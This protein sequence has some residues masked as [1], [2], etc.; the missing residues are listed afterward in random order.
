LR[1]EGLLAVLVQRDPAGV[2]PLL[3]RRI[4]EATAVGV[5]R[6][7]SLAAQALD[8]ALV[9]LNRLRGVGL[10]TRVKIARGQELPKSLPPL[11]AVLEA[12]RQGSFELR[13]REAELAQQGFRLRLME[14]DRYPSVTLEPFFEQEEALDKEQTV[15]VALRFPL[16]LWSRGAGEVGVG[17]ARVEQARA[18]VHLAWREVESKVTRHYRGLEAK[19]GVLRR[20]RGEAREQFREAAE[21]ADRHFRLGAVTV[22]AYVE[23]QT[24]YLVALEALLSTQAEALDDWQQLELCV[25]RSLDSVGG[26]GQR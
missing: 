7:A 8:E 21:L 25:G 23:M 16:P 6:D 22:A 26:V 24:G 13:V 17:E 11:G 15:G 5:E 14:K 3:D 9:E 18:A 2:A 4:L 1:L 19:L 10:S 12:A 20:W